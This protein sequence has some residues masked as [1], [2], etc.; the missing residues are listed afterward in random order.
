MNTA[1]MIR[2]L[3]DAAEPEEEEPSNAT[4]DSDPITKSTDF[5]NVQ[6]GARCKKRSFT[7]IE[8][9][10]KSDPVYKNFR[11]G[12]TALLT[13]SGFKSPE[14]PDRVLVFIPS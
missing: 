3:I 13:A 12:L 9:L 8:E 11:M 14:D 7:E 2:S 5:G 1:T 4:G 10:A 6:F